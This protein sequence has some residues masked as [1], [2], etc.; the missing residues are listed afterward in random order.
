MDLYKYLLKYFIL[1]VWALWERTPYLKHLK[2]LMKSQYFSRE[3]IQQIQWS[4]VQ[5]IL[6]HA[7]NNSPYYREKLDKAG[8]RPDEINDFNDF[9]KIPVL[10]KMEVIQNNE[11]HTE[12]PDIPENLSS[13]ID[14][15]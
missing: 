3:K 9:L 13:V 15:I 7:Y 2:Y 12:L 4:K 5:K 11:S 6:H 1:P 10:E 14:S 8:I